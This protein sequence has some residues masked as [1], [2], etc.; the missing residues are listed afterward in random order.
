M[1]V[2]IATVVQEEGNT[3]I[4]LC[5]I[6]HAEMPCHYEVQQIESGRIYTV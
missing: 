4:P 2:I 1:K 5:I 3:P 6:I